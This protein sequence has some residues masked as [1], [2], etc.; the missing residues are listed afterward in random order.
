MP[1][2]GPLAREMAILSDV[3]RSDI[4]IYSNLTSSLGKFQREIPTD[5]VFKKSVNQIPYS[6]AKFAL[7]RQGNYG[8]C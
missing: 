5:V 3:L 7:W 1:E 8:D 2:Q 6:K 4:K